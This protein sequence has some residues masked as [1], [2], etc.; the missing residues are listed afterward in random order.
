VGGAAVGPDINGHSRALQVRGGA[1]AAERGERRVGLR[2]TILPD[3]GFEG[4]LTGDRLRARL[5][6][7]PAGKGA[8]RLE[9]VACLFAFCRQLDVA[10]T[11]E[12]A[13]Q[14]HLEAFRRQEFRLE[15]P[16]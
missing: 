3:L 15:S 1:A 10:L 16:A 4:E 13:L 6:K 14:R 2:Q 7:E 8:A 9:Q 11:S 12:A 5:L